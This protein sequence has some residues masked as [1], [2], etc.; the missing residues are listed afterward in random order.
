[1]GWQPRF[2]AAYTHVSG[3]ARLS[4]NL[5]ITLAAVL[6]AQ[7][8][9]VGWGPVVTPGVEALT[10][11]RTFGPGRAGQDRRLEGQTALARHRACG[12]LGAQRPDLR[13]GRDAHAAARGQ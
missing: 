5:D 1:M 6:T 7:S 13:L 11:L 10:R 8:L 4:D 3:G 12:R 2:T 9:N